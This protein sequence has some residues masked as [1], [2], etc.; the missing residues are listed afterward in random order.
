M[1]EILRLED[2]VFLKLQRQFEHRINQL[3]VHPMLGDLLDKDEIDFAIMQILQDFLKVHKKGHVLSTSSLY[4]KNDLMQTPL[5]KAMFDLNIIWKSKYFGYFQIEYKLY[6]KVI[7]EWLDRR[8]QGMNSYERLLFWLY[9]KK[10]S[11][12]RIS[13]KYHGVGAAQTKE[14]SKSMA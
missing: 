6:T 7:E 5:F 10:G 3:F 9:K 2:T 13:S 12:L 14:F 4:A 1:S 8:L 11:T